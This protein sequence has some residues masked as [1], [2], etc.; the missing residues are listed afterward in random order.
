[1]KYRTR[2]YYIDGLI[3]GLQEFRQRLS[4]SAAPD[5]KLHEL[6][7]AVIGFAI[8]ST[9]DIRVPNVMFD[10]LKQRRSATEVVELAAV[11]AAYNMVARFLVAL[12]VNPEM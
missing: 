1:M 3:I 11:R 2:T 4:E 8:A 7:R 9:R 6:Q 10:A 12:E 5:F